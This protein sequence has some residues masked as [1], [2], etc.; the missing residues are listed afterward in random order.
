MARKAAAKAG[1]K[2]VTNWKE[3]LKKEA[4]VAKGMEAGV[5]SSNFFSLKGGKLTYND[6]Q[7]PDNAMIVSVVDYVLENTFY[8][9]DYDPDNPA[10]PVCYAFGTDED[11]MGPHEE[12]P[13][14]QAEKCAECPHNVFGS[15][16]R[17]RG[18]ACRNS[19]RLALTDAGTYNDSDGWQVMPDLP[20]HFDSSEIVF[21]KIPPTSLR[22]WAAYV[23]EVAAFHEVPPIGV[24]TH[25][26]VEDD[27]KDQFHVNFRHVR[28][29]TDDEAAVLI[30]KRDAL[31]SMGAL[32]QPYQ[33]IDE[34]EEPP[35]KK[36]GAKKPAAKRGARGG[37]RKY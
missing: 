19:R 16:D 23:K 21:L 27:D 34:A 2:A 13:D 17:G 20:E 28:A 32:E 3:G 37:S 14:P 12:S 36:R 24:L 25:I 4:E 15:A 6:N 5:G 31:R 29:I 26:A 9:E 30:P 22:A 10:S 33:Q 7:L 35:K 8:D 11:T 18:K 1:P